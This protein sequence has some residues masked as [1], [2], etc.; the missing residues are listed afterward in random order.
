MDTGS[1][2]DEEDGQVDNHP[3]PTTDS[4]ESASLADLNRCRV[5]R[6]MIVKHFLSPWFEDYITS[7]FTISFKRIVHLAFLR[8]M[9]SLLHRPGGRGK[10]I[11][12]LRSLKSDAFTRGVFAAFTRLPGLS[13]DKVKPYR[14]DGIIVDKGFEL[15]HG[16]ALKPFPMDKVSNADFSPVSTLFLDWT[17]L[18]LSLERV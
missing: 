5:T 7:A 16:K 15:Q 2:E 14:L 18:I 17:N 8:F 1:S 11:S 9:G 6:N 3:G 12:Y 10:R 4:E 13:K